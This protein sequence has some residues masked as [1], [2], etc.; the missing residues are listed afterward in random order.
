MDFVQLCVKLSQEAQ[1]LFYISFSQRRRKILNAGYS[2]DAVLVLISSLTADVCMIIIDE[3]L[4]I[5][6]QLHTLFQKECPIHL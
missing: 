1:L 5:E 6:H 3:L 4:I 2:R